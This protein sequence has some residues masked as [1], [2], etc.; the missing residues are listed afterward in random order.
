MEETHTSLT[1]GTY[2]GFLSITMENEQIRME[3]VP[4]LGGKLV[5]LI[6]KPSGKEWLL[7]SGE[8]SLRQ[9][10]YGS[11]FGE[12]DMSGWDECFPTINE[13]PWE[14]DKRVILPD[15]G[16]IWSLPWRYSIEE[17]E[18]VCSVESS[19]LSYQFIRSITMH[20][21]NTVRMKYRVDNR[22]DQ[23]M[24]FLWVPHPQFAM[25]EQ[26]RILLPEPMAEMLCVYAGHK[27]KEGETYAWEDVSLVSPAVTG[28]GR[29]FY[30]VGQVPISWSGLYGQE[31]ENFLI[32]SVPKEKVPYLGIWIDE[33]MFN[34]R[35]T[36]ALEPSIGYYDSLDKAV[37]NGSAQTIPAQASFEWYLDLT[38]GIGEWKS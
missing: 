10:H 2:K 8:R 12:W 34:D 28:D 27:L 21:G 32:V 23:P 3:I 17:N 7:D 29:K 15:H 33:G 25:T 24:P 4:D 5:S 31:S 1:T 13:C 38:I 35:V 19:L 9:P 11:S 20:A 18:V 36:C 37:S 6:Y 14:L 22:N 26:T 30:Y 16:E